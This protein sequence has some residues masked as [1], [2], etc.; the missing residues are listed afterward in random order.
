VIELVAIWVAPARSVHDVNWFRGS[1][2]PRVAGSRRGAR[3]TR[4]RLRSALLTRTPVHWQ[5]PGWVKDSGSATLP[6]GRGPR[7]ASAR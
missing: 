5:R 7:R 2:S 3:P 6:R 1:H 4:Q